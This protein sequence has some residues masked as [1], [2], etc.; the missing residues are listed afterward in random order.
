MAGAPTPTAAVLRSQTWGH[1]GNCPVH[2]VPQMAQ[3]HEST[4][5]RIGWSQSGWIRGPN[6]RQTPMA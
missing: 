6:S 2:R 5:A 4:P 3:V 1:A